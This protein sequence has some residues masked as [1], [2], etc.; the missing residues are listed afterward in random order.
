MWGQER[1][2][3]HA[4]E[5]A[6]L[7]GAK[8]LSSPHRILSKRKRQ[9]QLFW[10]DL[11]GTS[12]GEFHVPRVGCGEVEVGGGMRLDAGNLCEVIACCTL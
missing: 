8:S 9:D 1:G 4:E 11:P 6:E 10:K 7:H 5:G 12:V 2:R 3:G